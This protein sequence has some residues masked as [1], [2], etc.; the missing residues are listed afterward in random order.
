PNARGKRRPR[1]WRKALCGTSRRNTLV[2][3]VSFFM[4]GSLS[5]L[6]ANTYY[7][8]WLGL[9]GRKIGG[10]FA[11]QCPSRGSG[12]TAYPQK[13]DNSRPLHRR[14]VVVGGRRPFL[15]RSLPGLSTQSRWSPSCSRLGFCQLIRRELSAVTRD[16]RPARAAVSAVAGPAWQVPPDS[17]SAARSSG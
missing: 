3:T 9:F 11:G 15:R 4:R 5:A 13:V 7:G 8:H 2:M 10:R 14:A 6:R 12:V 17:G 1:K 16:L